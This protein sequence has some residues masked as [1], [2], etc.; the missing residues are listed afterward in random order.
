MRMRGY[1]SDYILSRLAVKG[2]LR[3]SIMD[4]KI[5]GPI[6][7]FE[8]PAT[9]FLVHVKECETSRNPRLLC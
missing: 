9:R 3:H 4:M 6:L 7:C 5:I 8:H 1:E 2:G